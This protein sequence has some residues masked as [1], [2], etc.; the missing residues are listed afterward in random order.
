MSKKRPSLLGGLLWTGIGVIFLLRNFGIG[1]DFWSLAARYWPILLI[2]LGLGKVI[3]YYRQKEGV[4]IG[5]GEVIGILLLLVIGTLV[6][7]VTHGPVGRVFRELPITIGGTHVR[8]GQ[9]LGS[10]YSYTEERSYPLTTATPVRIENS[11]GSVSVAPGSDQEVKVR[12]RK[13]VYE[14]DES[15]AKR[16]AAEIR[17]EAGPQGKAEATSF[18]IRTNRDALSAKDYRFNTDLEVF[19]PPKGQLQVQNSF[20]EVRTANLEGKLDLS[21][22]HNDL[23]IRDCTGEFTAANRYG[24]SRFLNLTGNVKVEA[25]GRVVAEGIRGNV[26]VQNEYNPVEVRN[27]EGQV[28]VTN[29]ESSV[30]LEKITQ[31]VVIQGRGTQITANELDGA[32]RFT[33]SHRRVRVEDVKAGVQAD[34]SYANVT[35]R[36][37]KGEVAFN[38]NSDRLNF[39]GIGGSLKVKAVGTAVSAGEVKGPVEIRTT[40]RD[41]ALSNISSSVTVNNEYGDVTLSA[42]TIDRDGISVKNK[43][44]A[45]ELFLP[46]EAGFEIEASARNGRVDSDFPGL[47]TVEAGP[48]SR[49]LRGKLR[50]GGPKILLENDY[51]NIR[52]RTRAGETAHSRSR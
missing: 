36:N 11:Y 31:P 34:T 20:G 3:D 50:S 38:S 12:I 23:E 8:P 28:S 30:S 46:E 32:L 21:T 26:T 7:K 2:L 41:V 24:D 39:E 19:L 5:I 49:V 22:S 16:I 9:W 25:R 15:N 13:V 10:S 14:K 18:L 43:N 35:L 17:L 45:I 51:G 29:T 37:I 33:T 1:P 27:V 52:L 40:L 47:Q 6:T 48:D 4:S 44:G 42:E